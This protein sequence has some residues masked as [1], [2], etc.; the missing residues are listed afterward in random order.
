MHLPS[1]RAAALTAAAL[2]LPLLPAFA[3]AAGAASNPTAPTS[4]AAT[5]TAAGSAPSLTQVQPGPRV[6]VRGSG[7]SSATTVPAPTRAALARASVRATSAHATAAPTSTWVVQFTGGTADQRAAFQ[8]AVD[9]WAS[10]IASPVPIRVNVVLRAQ[11]DVDI[12]GSAGPS[13]IGVPTGVPGVIPNTIYPIAL[14]NALAGEDLDPASADIEAEFSS[15][16]SVFS[17]G[18][19]PAPGTYDFETVALH[20]LGHGLGFIGNL[21]AYCGQ[22]LTPRP[23]LGGP[24]PE[25]PRG[26]W[27]LDTAFEA[28]RLPFVYD[29]FALRASP[30]PA[31][32]PFELGQDS[33]ALGLA[34]TYG[35]MAL[36]GPNLTDLR[37]CN[38][39]HP[40]LATPTTFVPGTSYSH[41]NEAA[42]PPGTPNSL[43]TPFIDEREVVHNPGPLTLAILRDLGWDA[44]RLPLTSA[45]SVCGPAATRINS[46]A[47]VEGTAPVDSTVRVWFRKRG[48][49]DFTLGRVLAP[50]LTGRFRFGYIASDAYVYFATA[51]NSVQSPVI[52]TRARP[53]IGGPANRSFPKGSLVT[54]IGR[55][56]PG[57]TVTL[58]FRPPGSPGD[59]YPLVRTARVDADGVWRYGLRLSVNLRF[60]VISSVGTPS[61]GTAFYRAV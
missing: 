56:V 35:E 54:A 24:L 40:I 23:C 39:V 59:S 20:E 15:D 48:E 14:A 58:R 16:P 61:A 46:I 57:T 34:L 50:S 32:S 8:R 51:N 4:T 5:S 49:T 3:P 52:L 21:Q 42:Y 38:P 36:A 43:M 1:P 18:G 13:Q 29:R 27:D 60:L 33:K 17:F 9:T 47:V 30:A 7:L 37:P 10:V 28:E 12:L 25:A 6:V 2:T 26:G 31:R 53:T 22:R 44:A 41:L 55:G 19:T 45:L 11:P